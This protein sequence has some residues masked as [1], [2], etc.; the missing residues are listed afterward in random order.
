MHSY[1]SFADSTKLNLKFD[2]LLMTQQ[3]VLKVHFS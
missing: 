2:M 1:L 3:I